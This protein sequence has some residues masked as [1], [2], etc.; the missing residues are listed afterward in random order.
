MNATPPNRMLA[1]S[2]AI[3]KRLLFLYPKAHRNAYG[4]DM[5]Q[6]FRDQSRDAWQESRHWGLAKLW[7]RVL[8]DLART[9]LAERL[10]NLNPHKTMSDKI[11]GLFRGPS[12]LATFF[13][14]ATV[15]FLL[16]LGTSIVITFLLPESYSST[17]RIEVEQYGKDVNVMD[18]SPPAGMSGFDPYFIQTTFEIM[19]SEVVLSNVIATLD[20]NNKWGKKFNHGETLKTSETMLILKNSMLLTPVRNTKLIA[21]TIYSDDPKEAAQI[22]NAEAESYRDYRERTRTGRLLQDIIAL[23]QRYQQGETEI[24]K[25][26]NKLNSLRG[27]LKIGSLISANPTPQEQAYWDEQRELDQM[28]QMQKLRSLKIDTEKL[29][30]EIPHSEMAQIVD[31]AQPGRFPVKP[32]KPLNIV[33]GIVGGG[34]L[35]LII[36]TIAMSISLQF[37][38]GNGR[39]PIPT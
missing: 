18:G 14:V 27:Q 33:I 15:V 28:L 5:T 3:F 38:K 19:Q 32:N 22:A 21:I 35:G 7:L 17:T 23:Q 6:L 4:A 36:G 30:A 10:S 16:T 29:D 24:E 31:R 20:L 26:Q 1:I 37:R 34:L 2:Q 11:A 12:P 25:T 9:S 13:T 39:N 8:P